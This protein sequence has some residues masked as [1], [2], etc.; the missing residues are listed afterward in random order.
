MNELFEIVNDIINFPQLLMDNCSY[1]PD[2]F[3]IAFLKTIYFVPILVL[4]YFLIEVI[5][6]YII[7]NIHVF[8]KFLR[9]FESLFGAIV[10]IIPE[11]NI[12]ILTSL[13]YSRN[14]I[15]RGTLLA[16]LIMCS[17]EVLPILFIEPTK[18][19]SII[20]L[21]II[22]FVLA[23]AIG[24]IVDI[25]ETILNLRI[26]R[27]DNLNAVNMD[28]EEYGC[29]H[30]LL[31]TKEAHPKLIKHTITHTVYMFI[32][33]LLFLSAIYAL[34]EVYGS[35]EN[36]AAACLYNNPLIIFAIAGLGLIPNCAVSVLIV[37]L[38]A[39]GIISFPAFLAGTITSAGLGMSMLDKRSTKR[40]ASITSI[41]L[42]ISAV[43]AGIGFYYNFLGINSLSAIF[44][45]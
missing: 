15:S 30:H 37:L 13:L 3:K 1:L 6:K 8:I 11:C 28:I 5:E 2:S 33:V 26:K 39:V 14:I 10:G 18:A 35:I 4:L 27:K 42:Y 29:C 12:A 24:F 21:L 34:G 38:Y 31:N 40:D 19:L 22:K 44:I 36:L 25:T 9:S 41:I 43:A 17:D 7:K 45:K 23:L 32:F 16:C 20:P